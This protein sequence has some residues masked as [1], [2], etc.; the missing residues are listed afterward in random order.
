M[1]QIEQ[2]HRVI[3]NDMYETVCDVVRHV[4]G[5]DEELERRMLI[6][7]LGVDSIMGAE[8]RTDLE[9]DGYLLASNLSV[10]L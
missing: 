2:S 8:L 10:R 7:E 6:S 3:S 9:D 5:A 4:T 1:G